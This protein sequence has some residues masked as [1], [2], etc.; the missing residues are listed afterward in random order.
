MKVWDPLPGPLLFDDAAY[1]ALPDEVTHEQ[2]KSIRNQ[3]E[4]SSRDHQYEFS[5]ALPKQDRP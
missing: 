2:E 4:G 1:F 5:P 3:L